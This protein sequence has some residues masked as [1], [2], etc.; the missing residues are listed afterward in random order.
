MAFSMRSLPWARPR[1]SRAEA[2]LAARGNLMTTIRK[3][4]RD[5]RSRPTE[6][7]LG[8]TT[9]DAV[10]QIMTTERV[11]DLLKGIGPDAGEQLDKEM[12]WKHLRQIL[13]IL[14]TIKWNNWST[15][16]EVFLRE[17][18]TF[19]R[20]ER[21]DH[22]LPFLDL[23][24]LEEDVREDFDDVQYLFKPIIIEENTHHTY[25]EKYRV[26]FIKSRERGDGGFGVVTEE[27]VE[28]NQIKYEYDNG[29]AKTL[30]PRVRSTFWNYQVLL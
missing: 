11:G 22:Q 24:F 3:E 21:G 20:P 7:P 1:G 8:F 25:T 19:N 27:L 23:S 28:K 26:P 9:A 6:K 2:M 4:L 15:F 13:A 5:S 16:E 29:A 30:N 17:L 18:D 10:R 12:I 14:I